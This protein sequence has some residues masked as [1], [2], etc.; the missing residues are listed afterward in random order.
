M[1]SYFDCAPINR[2]SESIEEEIAQSLRQFEPARERRNKKQKLSSIKK[3]IK[4]I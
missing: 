1:S 2:S 4:M 3:L